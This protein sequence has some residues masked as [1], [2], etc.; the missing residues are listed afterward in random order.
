VGP[1]AAVTTGPAGGTATTTPASTTAAADRATVSALA[2][3]LRQTVAVRP[4]VLGAIEGVQS[5]Q[6]DPTAASQTL[7]AAIDTRHTILDG[8]RHLSLDGV[9]NG[10][11]LVAVL[12]QSLTASIQ[13]DTDYQAWMG[14]VNATGQCVGNPNQDAN[15]QHGQ[16]ESQSATAAKTTFVGLWDAIAPTYHEPTYTATQ[17]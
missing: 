12:T 6:I 17:I 7:R 5:C 3:D 11:A 10:T 2:D 15:Y 8:L 14:D 4:S 16:A 9:P 13:A 1:G